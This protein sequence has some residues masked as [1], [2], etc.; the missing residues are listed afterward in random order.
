MDE[1]TPWVLEANQTCSVEDLLIWRQHTV[2]PPLSAVTESFCG[3]STPLVING[4]AVTN[5]RPTAKVFA[6]DA[7]TGKAIWH[8]D[9]DTRTQAPPIEAN[10]SVLLHGNGLVSCLDA[11]SGKCRWTWQSQSDLAINSEL[12]AFED[13][14]FLCLGNGTIVC[15]DACSGAQVWATRITTASDPRSYGTP[16]AFGSIVASGSNG[17]RVAGV[18]I[19]SGRIAWRS[20]YRKGSCLTV[21]LEGNSVLARRWTS[22]ERIDM[23]TGQAVSDWSFAPH[24]M[25]DLIPTH[26]GVFVAVRAAVKLPVE[27]SPHMR[28]HPETLRSVEQAQGWSIE[29]P[30]FAM[31]HL[32]WSK[33]SRLVYESTQSGLGL[34][35]PILGRRAVV[36]TGFAG[37]LRREPRGK[38]SN[39]C[40]WNDSVL[41]VEGSGDVLRLRH[42]PVS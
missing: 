39:P 14:V 8:T 15:L 31:P 9:L 38:T 37:H 3:R 42:P 28:Y 30:P 34:V 33:E 17:G 27:G 24:S 2:D 23:M 13:R 19:T 16:I 11:T 22:V 20:S 41:L 7:E 36:V 5:I 10:G 29:Y 21:H 35:D 26:A 18:E 1:Q 4:I 25:S 40:F 12:T 6:F 32:S